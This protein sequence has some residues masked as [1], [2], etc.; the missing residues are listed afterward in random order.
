MIEVSLYVFAAFRRHHTVDTLSRSMM[1]DGVTSSLRRA[2]HAVTGTMSSSPLYVY[3]L[4]RYYD[5]RRRALRYSEL[6]IRH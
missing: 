1:L 2:S 6:V 3:E 5:T 4:Y